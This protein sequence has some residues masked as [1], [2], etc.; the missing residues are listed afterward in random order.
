MWDAFKAANG[1]R[2]DYNPDCLILQDNVKVTKDDIPSTFFYTA[3]ELKNANDPKAVGS[4][5]DTCELYLYCGLNSESANQYEYNM[6][7]TLKFYGN[8]FT[9]DFSAFPLVRRGWGEKTEEGKVVSHATAFRC[10]YGS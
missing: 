5:K 3:E 2:T 1:L 7:N 6:N 8:Y 10:Q 4:M 9:I